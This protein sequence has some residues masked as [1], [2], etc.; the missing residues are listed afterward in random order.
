MKTDK[1]EIK[2]KIKLIKEYKVYPFTPIHVTC[3]IK[4]RDTYKK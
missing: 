2:Q 3:F 1:R 4:K